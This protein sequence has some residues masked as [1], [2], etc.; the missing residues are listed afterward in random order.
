MELVPFPLLT[1]QMRS[2]ETITRSVRTPRTASAPRRPTIDPRRRSIFAGKPLGA[3][4]NESATMTPPSRRVR[5]SGRPSAGRFDS[6]RPSDPCTN[7]AGK[8]PIRRT[9]PES[10][11][12][13]LRDSLVSL[14]DS[15]LVGGCSVVFEVV[16]L[17]VRSSSGIRDAGPP[18]NSLLHVVVETPRAREPN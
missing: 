2:R 4:A 8:R 14:S 9:A 10:S 11:G 5:T 16:A 7:A 17:S 18:A 12:L 13:A 3:L 1:E 6:R 15:S